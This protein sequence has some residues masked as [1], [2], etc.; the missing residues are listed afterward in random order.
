MMKNAYIHKTVDWV[1]VIGGAML[2]LGFDCPQ[3][4]PFIT[5]D[6]IRFKVT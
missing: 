2:A 1:S 5:L 6:S 4:A 3:T